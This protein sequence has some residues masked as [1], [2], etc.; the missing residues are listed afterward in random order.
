MNS[1]LWNR[2]TKGHH[3]LYKSI[4]LIQCNSFTFGIIHLVLTVVSFP[5][6]FFHNSSRHILCPQYATYPLI[7]A[8]SN[9]SLLDSTN[10]NMHVHAQSTF[11]LYVLFHGNHGCQNEYGTIMCCLYIHL[12]ITHTTFFSSLSTLLINTHPCII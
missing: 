5:Y 1:H 3:V 12:F 11:Y 10:S 9:S 2:K 7:L 6:H 8:S 4:I